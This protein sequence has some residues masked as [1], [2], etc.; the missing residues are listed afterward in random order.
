M[1]K[2]LFIGAVVT[3]LTSCDVSSNYYQIYKTN[4]S[5]NVFKKGDLLVF[6]DENCSVTYDLWNVGGNV[7]FTIYNKSN[8]NLY[9]NLE[10]SFFIFNGIANNYY[11]NRV[12]S[13]S[14]NSGAMYSSGVM[15]SKS[16]TGYNF[17][18]LLQTNKVAVSGNTGIVNSS[19]HSVTYTEEKI[20]SIPPKTSKNVVEYSINN[21]LYSDCDLYKYPT[22]KQINTKSFTKSD[23]PFVFSNKISY[24]TDSPEK[25]FRFDNSFYVSEIANYPESEALYSITDEICGKKSMTKSYYFNDKSPD[26]FY[27][28]YV[29]SH[30]NW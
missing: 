12:F 21:S 2:L 25:L 26:K 29:K 20:M 24:Y 17:L 13:N 6:E 7:G 22:K 1:K 27:V 28:K 14:V 18:N 8:K 4:T 9:L 19:G 3:F 10:E 11:K 16:V 30:N 15:A 5:D 23:S